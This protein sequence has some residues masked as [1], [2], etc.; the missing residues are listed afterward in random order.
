MWAHIDGQQ[1]R[2]HRSFHS[3]T[4]IFDLRVRSEP[5]L[6]DILAPF[7][8]HFFLAVIDMKMGADTTRI[9]MGKISTVSSIQV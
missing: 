8:A 6:F 3:N 4:K 2:H 9:E 7:F 5:S 1:K